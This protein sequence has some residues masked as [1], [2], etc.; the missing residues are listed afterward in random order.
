MIKSYLSFALVSLLTFSAMAAGETVNFDKESFMKEGLHM[1]QTSLETHRKDLGL[2]SDSACPAEG[3]DLIED[4]HETKGALANALDSMDEMMKVISPT[5]AKKKSDVGRC[6]ACK[7]TNVVSSYA[8][9]S[10]EKTMPIPECGNRAAETFAID[11]ASKEGA[12]DFT[13]KLLSG[14][15]AEGK[16]LQAACPDPCA[17]YVT[18]AQTQ[19]DNGTTH[20]TLTVQCGQPRKGSVLFATYEYKAGVV[21][22]WTCSK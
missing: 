8:S 15:N 9:I 20:L 13:E 5:V 1:V 7:Q 17:Y 16:R 19:Q 22:Q 14:D 2:A 4:I 3:M 11:V 18:T 12:K 6:G 21:H 10:P